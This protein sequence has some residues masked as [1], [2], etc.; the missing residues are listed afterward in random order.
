MRAQPRRTFCIAGST[1]TVFHL[2]RLRSAPLHGVLRGVPHLHPGL[3]KLL[4]GGLQWLRGLRASAHHR[5]VWAHWSHLCLRDE[6]V[7]IFFFLFICSPILFFSVVVF[8]KK[9]FNPWPTAS[10]TTFITWPGQS[11]TSTGGRAGW[12]SVL[13]CSRWCWWPMWSFKRNN[14]PPTLPG[15]QITWVGL[16]FI[17]HHL[18]IL[19]WLVI[20]LCLQCWL[21]SSGDKHFC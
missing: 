4:G 16:F 19:L 7:T 20:I 13:W 14:T 21:V 18:W 3:G 5:A 11:P 8:F 1:R 15:T 12:W 10:A 6:K 2:G 9:C 17:L